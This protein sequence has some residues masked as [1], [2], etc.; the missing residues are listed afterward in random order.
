M[1]E[2]CCDLLASVEVVDAGLR[3]LQ[4]SNVLVNGSG[5]PRRKY[6]SG[7]LKSIPTLFAK[8]LPAGEYSLT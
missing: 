2:T 7:V 1:S 4:G 3:K 5:S 8:S 6:S